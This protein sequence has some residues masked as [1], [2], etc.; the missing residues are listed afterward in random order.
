MSQPAEDLQTLRL[1][2]DKVQKLNDLHYAQASS[3]SRVTI[4]CEIQEDGTWRGVCARTG[5]P[6]ALVDAFVLSLRFFIQN[7]ERT[8]LVNMADLYARTPL[9]AQLKARFISA[10]KA[11]NSFLDAPNN[12]NLIVDG[13]PLSHREI[14]DVFVYGDLA[15]ANSEKHQRF[16]RWMSFP[17]N[18][19]LLQNCF[20]QTLA[21]MLQALNFIADLN[22]KAIMQIESGIHPE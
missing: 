15:H 22:R 19:A 18:A 1:F 7:N 21:A 20:D 6:S 9:D 14:M 3:N 17:P 11:F 12:L 2:N 16:Q 10:R 5:P 8:S 13:S 4:S